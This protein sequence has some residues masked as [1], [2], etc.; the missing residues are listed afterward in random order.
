MSS[1]TFDYIIVGG[2]IG[3]CVTASRLAERDPNLQILLIEAG[4]DAGDHPMVQTPAG[5]FG[6]RDT[7]LNWNY[8]SVPQQHLGERVT[9]NAAGKALGGGSVINSAAWLRGESTDYDSWADRVGDPRWSYKGMLPYFLKTERYFTRDTD[10]KEHGFEGPVEIQSVS[11]SGRIYPLRERVK[12]LW[13]TGGI[14][15]TT[16]ASAR[17]LPAQSLREVIENWHQGKRQIANKCYPPRHVKVLTKSL[18]EK[19]IFTKDGEQLRATS[20]QLDDGQVHSCRKEIILAAGAYRTPQILMLSGIGPASVLEKYKI[21]VVFE[22]PEVG[23]NFHDHLAVNLFWKLKPSSTGL[24]FGAAGFDQ[25]A[26][27]NG[28]PIDFVAYN[29]LPT[30]KL[31]QALKT[32]EPKTTE[33]DPLITP[34]RTH[35]EYYFVYAGYN[36]AAPVVPLDG[37]HVMTGVVGYLPTSRGTVTIN[38][39]K[40]SDFPIIDNNYYATELDRAVLRYGLRDQAKAMLETPEGRDFISHE[41]APDGCGALSSQSTDEELDKRVQIS[42]NTLY[43]AGGTASMGTVVDTSLRVNG[44]QGLRVADAS[45]MPVPLAGHYQ[46]CVYALGEQAVDLIL[47]DAA[48]R[49]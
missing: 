20:V 26:H 17:P 23:R 3:G 35:L 8:P 22:Q 6:V 1:E 28:V 4:N 24:S 48:K 18:V 12:A 36:P 43:H 44:V 7:E 34:A 45:V 39:D 15:E 27:A 40:I 13:A 14:K 19:I 49:H 41:I 42:A 33:H 16:E 38:S 32:D 30:D 9:Y 31:L 37:T 10:I 21:P 25:P 11:S 5:A 47:E 46:A 29:T 2:G